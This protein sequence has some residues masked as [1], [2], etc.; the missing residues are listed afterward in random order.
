M[1][2][3][4]S[5]SA[6]SIDLLIVINPHPFTRS[7]TGN[8]FTKERLSTILKDTHQPFPPIPSSIDEFVSTGVNGRATFFGCDPPN[9]SAYPMVIYLPNAP[10]INGDDPI[11]KYVLAFMS[12]SIKRLT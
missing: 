2:S 10:P 5:P 7:G 6:L 8:I 4:I 11:T 9:S 12:G 1:I 3:I